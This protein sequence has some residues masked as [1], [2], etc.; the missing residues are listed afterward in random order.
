MTFQS[1]ENQ[2]EL[3]LLTPIRI[4]CNEKPVIVKTVRFKNPY[5]VKVSEQNGVCYVY[6]EDYG[7]FPI[8]ET[9]K[10]ICQMLNIFKEDFNKEFEEWYNKLPADPELRRLATGR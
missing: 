10:E 9:M 1:K 6:I 4:I 7:S 3:H 2:V 8:K 5:R